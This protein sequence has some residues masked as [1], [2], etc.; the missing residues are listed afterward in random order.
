MPSLLRQLRFERSIAPQER[1]APVY[2]YEKLGTL[3]TTRLLKIVKE[4][5]DGDPGAQVA[6]LA[7]PSP[8]S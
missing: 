3:H 8:N 4:V 1:C 6:L 7:H 5:A 2:A